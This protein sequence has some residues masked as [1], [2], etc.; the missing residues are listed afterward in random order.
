[1]YICYKHIHTAANSFSDGAQ[2]ADN[3]TLSRRPITFTTLTWS[4]FLW[5]EFY[6]NL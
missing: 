5:P 3:E 1:M 6:I 2:C 4:L